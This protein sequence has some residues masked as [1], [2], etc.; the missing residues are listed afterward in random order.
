VLL[1]I[2]PFLLQDQYWNA[3]F[4]QRQPRV[5]CSSY[6]S[7][8]AHGVEPEAD[9]GFHS[10]T[11]RDDCLNFIAKSRHRSP[12]IGQGE[13]HRDAVAGWLVPCKGLAG[14]V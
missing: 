14:S 1:A 7:K 4:E 12:L 10:P 2:K 13:I 9:N 11:R 8:N 5:M 3:A 6:N